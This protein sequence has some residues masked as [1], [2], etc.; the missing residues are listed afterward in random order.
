[1]DYKKKFPIFIEHDV[2][3]LDTAATSQKPQEVI[4]S[5]VEYYENYN[6]NPGRGSHALSIESSGIVNS[7]RITVKDFINAKE[8]EEV[9]FTKNTTEAIN[10]L[11]YS[12]GLEFINEGDEIILGISNHH[13]N[14]VPWQFVASKKKAKLKYVHLD[15][16][17]QFDLDD[18]QYK[19]TEKTK[20]VAV[21]AVV[22]VTGVIQPIKEIIELAHLK[23]ALVL[24]DAAQSVLHFGHNV[25][26]LDADF[27]VFS[28]HKIFAPM[29]VGVLYGKRKLLEGIPPFLYGGDMIEFVTE[30][31][32]TYAP[33]PNKFE[34]G[35]PNVEAIYG[36]QKAIEFI[37]KIGYDTINKIERELDLQALF[38][39]GKLGFVELYLADN[40]DR[41]GVIAFNVK[42]VHSHDVA[43]ILDS[44]GVAV[45]SGHHCA[46]PLMNYLNVPSCCRASFSI[47]NTHEDIYKLI[48][49][50]KK[51]K[52]VFGI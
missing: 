20:I 42:G 24:I 47:Y 39:I 11:A 3:Y 50:L 40:V 49:A 8:K 38:E 16:N 1:M 17:G 13:A 30:Q 2:H 15:K 26:E 43:F 31:E 21:S 46:Q 9:I 25:Q 36:L 5:I 10:L 23:G 29:G 44:Y 27:L 48:E 14:I 6:G 35:T 4:D 45:R 7:S 28:G 19:L 51:V 52:E 18:F 34:G 32:S 41:V 33:I 37:N 12:Y 22:N